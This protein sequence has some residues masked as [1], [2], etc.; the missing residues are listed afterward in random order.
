MPVRLLLKASL[1]WPHR[2]FWR[3]FFTKRLQSISPA[4]PVSTYSPTGLMGCPTLKDLSAN[5]TWQS[6]RFLDEDAEHREQVTCLSSQ[7]RAGRP[8]EMPRD[9][10]LLPNLRDCICWNENSLWNENFPVPLER[11]CLPRL[12]TTYHLIWYDFSHMFFVY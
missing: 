12:N 11:A 8:Q 10:H 7:G 2:D 5:P 3:F 1:H 9:K 4:G 6:S